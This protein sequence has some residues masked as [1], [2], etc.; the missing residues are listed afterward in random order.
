MTN[1]S[2]DDAELLATAHLDLL[3]AQSADITVLGR[4]N[5]QDL[6]HAAHALL[7]AQPAADLVTVIPQP[8]RDVQEVAA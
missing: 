4:T 3:A 5:R 8:T 7:Q 6:I 1:L 2:I